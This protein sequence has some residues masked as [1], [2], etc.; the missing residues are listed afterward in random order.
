MKKNLL[1]TTVKPAR[2]RGRPSTRPTLVEMPG[3][4][5][6]L[7]EMR[8]V[9]RVPGRPGYLA[10]FTVVGNKF[11]FIGLPAVVCNTHTCPVHS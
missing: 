11:F 1:P 2:Y 4:G 10:G 9:G 7:M 3:V 8:G 6:V 5:R